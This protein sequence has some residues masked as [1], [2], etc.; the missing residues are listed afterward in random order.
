MADCTEH[1]RN[2]MLLFVC[3]RVW[4]GE[5]LIIVPVAIGFFWWGG[6]GVFLR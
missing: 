1:S 3:C 6:G 4:L 5:V 2:G